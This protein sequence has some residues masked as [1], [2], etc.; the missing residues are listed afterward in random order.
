MCP[1]FPNFFMSGPL[2]LSAASSLGQ[3]SDVSGIQDN[4]GL[5]V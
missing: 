3:D 2:L 5:L 4:Y 1:A